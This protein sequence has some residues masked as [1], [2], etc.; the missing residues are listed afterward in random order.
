[1]FFNAI[2]VGLLIGLAM[3]GLMILIDQIPWLAFVVL[4]YLLVWSIRK[5]YAPIKRE[6][7]YGKK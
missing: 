7:R 2:A 3:Q 4:A 1:M 5:S 6:N